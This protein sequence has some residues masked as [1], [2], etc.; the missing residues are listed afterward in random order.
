[1]RF[2][3][4]SP[5]IP[6]RL[7]NSLIHVRAAV[8]KLSLPDGASLPFSPPWLA[9][10]CWSSMVFFP[11]F[12]VSN[13]RCPGYFTWHFPHYDHLYASQSRRRAD[14]TY[15]TFRKKSIAG[16]SE[17]VPRKG[18]SVGG[19]LAAHRGEERSER[20]RYSEQE[21]KNSNRRRAARKK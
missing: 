18:R 20:Q 21:S 3:S 5:L 12:V 1:M 4:R 6:A 7:T 11:R 15:P 14:A 17:I 10:L 8:R 16:F 19:R 9:W 2:C 13:L